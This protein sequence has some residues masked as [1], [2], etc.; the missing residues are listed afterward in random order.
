MVIA[1]PITIQ[2]KVAMKKIFTLEHKL[3]WDIE[4]PPELKKKMHEL[5]KKIMEGRTVCYHHSLC[6]AYTIKPL[7]LSIFDLVVFF[8]GSNMAYSAVAYAVY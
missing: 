3:E 4:L 5:F 8:D 6:G 7:T 1:S 2:L